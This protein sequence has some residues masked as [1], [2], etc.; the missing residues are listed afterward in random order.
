MSGVLS[1]RILQDLLKEYAGRDEYKL[2]DRI[3]KFIDDA[4]FSARLLR[5]IFTTCAKSGI[6]RLTR[7]KTN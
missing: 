6:L 5:K 3:D 1:R 4:A 7:K 2:E